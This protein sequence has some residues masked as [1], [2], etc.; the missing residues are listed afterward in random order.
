MID[1]TLHS[2]NPLAAQYCNQLETALT[3]V[4]YPKP[5]RKQFI[6]QIRDSILSY[7]ESHPD[8]TL[9]DLYSNFGLP[10][11]AADSA[12]LNT[13]PHK[14]KG[15]LKSSRLHK[16][17]F[18]VII[19]FFAFML[20]GQLGMLAINRYVSQPYIIESPATVITGP[21]PTDTP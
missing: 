16:F 7:I 9:N 19:A 13:E 4:N 3:E 12:L 2:E 17:L 6:E 18:A 14:L 10:Q 5:L 1:F 20:L 11:D 21:L 15:E 8:A